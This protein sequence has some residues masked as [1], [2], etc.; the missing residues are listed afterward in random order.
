VGF[1]EIDER[2]GVRWTRTR[3]REMKPTE[4]QLKALKRIISEGFTGFRNGASTVGW[5]SGDQIDGAWG[6]HG[7]TR[8]EAAWSV[9]ACGRELSRTVNAR[10]DRG[11][12]LVFFLSDLW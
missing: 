11:I 7:R 4:G 8:R 5:P 6:G 1:E 9:G 3:R 12:S 10:I 2:S